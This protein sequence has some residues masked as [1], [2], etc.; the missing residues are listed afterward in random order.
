MTWQREMKGAHG[1]K[2]SNRM[3]WILWDYPELSKWNHLAQSPFPILRYPHHACCHGSGVYLLAQK[4]KEHVVLSSTFQTEFDWVC[5]QTPT[6]RMLSLSTGIQH[7]ECQRKF[8]LTMEAVATRRGS[9]GP[10]DHVSVLLGWRC[11]C[12]SHTLCW[13][14]SCPPQTLSVPR[15]QDLSPEDSRHSPRHCKHNS[16]PFLVIV[17]AL[18][19]LC[20]ILLYHTISRHPFRSSCYKCQVNRRG[21][22]GS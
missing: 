20:N 14:Q 1:I 17:Q 5:G 2:V 18:Q 13:G 19:C 16:P 8:L 21:H 10:V 4:T 15:V 22:Q 3:V 12:I 11:S 7:Q 9:Q 6:M